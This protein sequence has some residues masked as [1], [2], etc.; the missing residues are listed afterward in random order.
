[1]VLFHF[2]ASKPGY[3]FSGYKIQSRQL[4]LQ[5]KFGCNSISKQLSKIG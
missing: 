5:K 2:D 3:W 4:T 1:M